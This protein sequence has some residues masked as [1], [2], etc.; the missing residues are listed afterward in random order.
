[1]KCA[2]SFPAMIIPFY[3][4]LIS[5]PQCDTSR[6][7]SISKTTSTLHSDC[8]E[9]CHI[10]GLCSSLSCRYQRRECTDVMMIPMRVNWSIFFVSFRDSSMPQAASLAGSFLF[11]HFIY[12][13]RLFSFALLVKASLVCHVLSPQLL[14]FAIW[15]ICIYLLSRVATS[16]RP[17]GQIFTGTLCWCSSLLAFSCEVSISLSI[18]FCLHSFIYGTLSILVPT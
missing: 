17:V 16:I 6:V 3:L 14:R 4:S 15:F 13:H 10:N 11:F 12:K 5:T 2:F 18:K 1:M 8:S 9:G 7:S